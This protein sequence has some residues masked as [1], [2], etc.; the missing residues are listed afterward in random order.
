MLAISLN[1]RPLPPSSA[2]AVRPEWQPEIW[3]LMQDCWRTDR[4]KRPTMGSVEKKLMSILGKSD[5]MRKSLALGMTR[6]PSVSTGNA[7]G[8]NV[9]DLPTIRSP[10]RTSTGRQPSLQLMGINSTLASASPPEVGSEASTP[11]AR[12]TEISSRSKTPS[13]AVGEADHTSANFGIHDGATSDEE[14][15]HQTD[16]H[17]Y[18]TPLHRPLLKIRDPGSIPS[19]S[20]D[21]SPITSPSSPATSIPESANFSLMSDLFFLH[22]RNSTPESVRT[23][24]LQKL[25][26][27]DV[28]ESRNASIDI[29]EGEDDATLNGHEH[30]SN[31]SH[32][33]QASLPDDSFMGISASESTTDLINEAFS[34][35]PINLP[36]TKSRHLPEDVRSLSSESL[37]TSH[38]PFPPGLEQSHKKP[39]N[40]PSFDDFQSCQVSLELLLEEGTRFT[41]IAPES[42]VLR[43]IETADITILDLY[44]S[45]RSAHK[46]L[47]DS[48]QELSPLF[49]LG[50]VRKLF[51]VMEEAIKT[52]SL[53]Y[54]DYADGLAALDALLANDST[55]S[56]FRHLFQVCHKFKYCYA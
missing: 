20:V 50:C 25:S 10:S 40:H 38:P 49:D 16:G 43:I 54:Q 12:A 37:N 13:N 34:R 14:L 30:V 9:P 27:E 36:A 2:S 52:L 39:E 42:D 53:V 21:P 47:L 5:M 48:V 22:Y 41:S 29:L 8:T 4:R 7:E 44:D 28:S 45:M 31:A 11:T 15:Q 51:D 56:E 35:P 55:E 32:H 6:R 17:P 26:M 23:D 18:H 3:T 19:I 33:I 1:E 24:E 46:V